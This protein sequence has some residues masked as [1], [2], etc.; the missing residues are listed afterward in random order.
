MNKPGL[1]VAVVG[2]GALG[3]RLLLGLARLPISCITIIDG[4]LVESANLGRQP[5]Y[6][7]S[8][9]GLRKAEAAAARL[10]TMQPHLDV[11]ARSEFLNAPNAEALLSRRTIVADCTDDLHAKVAIDRA[12]ARLGL[13]LVSG[14]LHAGQGQML[15]SLDIQSGRSSRTEIFKGRIGPDQDGC[16]M[17]SVPLHVMDAV[18]CRMAASIAGFLHGTRSADGAL[19]V[20]D[21]RSSE[22]VT[23]QP[24]GHD[25][26]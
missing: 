21:G 3:T 20:F 17:R 14:A 24:E 1:S 25:H 2:A 18:S 12:C 19:L 5:L 15:E 11:D 13:P 6:Q 23:F 22:W 4:D 8:D 7:A 16:D 9:I 26:G 10:R